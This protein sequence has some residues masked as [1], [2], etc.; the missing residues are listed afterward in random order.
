MS[1]RTFWLLAWMCLAFCMTLPLT[2]GADILF[3]N[4][5]NEIEG[6]VKSME[7]GRIL[8]VPVGGREARAYALEDVMKVRFVEKYGVP[9]EKTAADISEP[10]LRSAVSRRDELLAKYAK[11]SHVVI[12]KR[13]AISAGKSSVRLRVHEAFLVV[14]ESGKDEANISISYTKPYETVRLI[15]GRSITDD[16][17]VCVDDTAIK[18]ASLHPTE[19]EYDRR[20]ALKFSIP[21]VRKGSIV[22]YQY[23]KTIRVGPEH[24]FLYME[25][26][27]SFTPTLELSLRF[28]YDETDRDKAFHGIISGGV[29]HDRPASTAKD[30]SMVWKITRKTPLPMVPEPYSPPYWQYLETAYAAYGSRGV[31]HASPG[32]W[33]DGTAAIL[34]AGY[35]EA[36]KGGLPRKF[37]EEAEKACEGLSDPENKARR[38]FAFVQDRIDWSPVDGRESGIRFRKSSEV[39]A[40]GRANAMDKGVLLHKLLEELGVPSTLLISGAMNRPCIDRMPSLAV[41]S[42]TL[43]EVKGR[44]GERLYLFPYEDTTPAGMIPAEY[45]DAVALKVDGEGP[46]LRK[47]EYEPE[48]CRTER[49]LMVRLDEDGTIHVKEALRPAYEQEKRMRTWKRLPE[50]DIRKAVQTYLSGLDSRAELHSFRLENLE[51]PGLKLV[52]HLD[53]SIEGYAITGGDLM[54]VPLP[55]WFPEQRMVAQEKRKIPLQFSSPFLPVYTAV[56]DSNWKPP[57]GYSILYLPGKTGRKSPELGIE[58]SFSVKGN[59]LIDMSMSYSRKRRTYTSKDYPALKKLLTSIAETLDTY[60]VLERRTSGRR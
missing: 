31:D 40:S 49:I 58:Y 45:V 44:N 56:L 7:D 12:F 19:K 55:V 25:P 26:L 14:K 17:I 41:L 21:G 34:R 46:L 9:G 43:V 50:T 47:L 54:V 32:K 2:A 5:G 37:V 30:G 29:P 13:T 52:V 39:T 42:G 59:S 27:V 57:R 33:W 48:E 8:F 6:T 53:Y 38:A 15:F 18:D 10:A 36:T 1:N 20:Y 22:E 11:W 16:E 4:D 35:L 60:M 51:D 23:E 28:E 24:D 3:L